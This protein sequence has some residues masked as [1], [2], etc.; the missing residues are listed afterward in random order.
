MF[1]KGKGNVTSLE[2]GFRYQYG[3]I[4]LA[5]RML[6]NKELNRNAVQTIIHEATHKYA[7]TWD[8]CYFNEDGATPTTAYM[9]G[10]AGITPDRRGFVDRDAAMQNADSFAWFAYKISRPPDSVKSI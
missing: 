6:K 4:N 2:D 10:Y 8:Y 1:S 7:G 5:A 9:R 3:V